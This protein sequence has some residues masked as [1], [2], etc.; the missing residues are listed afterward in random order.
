MKV[1]VLALGMLTCIRK[2]LRPAARAQGR[3]PRPRH[4][5][6]RGSAHLRDDPHGRHARRLPDREPGADV[7]AAAAEAAHLLRS[8]HRGGDRPARARSRA[9]WSTPI[10]AAARAWRPSPI[11]SRS[12]SRCWARPS[13]CRCSRSRRCGS[14]SI[15]AGFTPGE[16]DELR[17]VHGDLHAT[18]GDRALSGQADRAAWSRAATSATSPSAASA[19]SRASATTASPRATPPPSR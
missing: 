16:A 4:H 15:A 19:R 8:R 7:D 17:R 14:P 3:R 6:G 5:P 11:P 18:G 2:R 9:T 1:D 10:C 12:W 13:A